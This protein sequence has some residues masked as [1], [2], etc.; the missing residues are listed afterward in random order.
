MSGMRKRKHGEPQDLLG[1]V[2][3]LGCGVLVGALVGA[4]LAPPW[5]L[6]PAGAVVFGLLSVLYGDRAW[7]GLGAL[8]RPLTWWW[9]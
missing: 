4:W 9:R 2:L 6:V 3:Y 7:D 1:V 8:L 5:L